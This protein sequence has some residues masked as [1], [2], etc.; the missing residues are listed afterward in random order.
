MGIGNDKVES[1]KLK[2][3]SKLRHYCSARMIVWEYASSNIEVEGLLH[4]WKQLT[5]LKLFGS[6]RNMI[7]TTLK[8]Y[9]VSAWVILW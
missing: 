7:A 5:H 1:L 4:I 3:S 6:T 8:G 9:G 2:D